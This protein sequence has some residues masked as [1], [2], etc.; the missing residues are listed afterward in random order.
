MFYV[1][2]K[3]VLM[4]LVYVLTLNQQRHQSCDELDVHENRNEIFISINFHEFDYEHPIISLSKDINP[5][6]QLKMRRICV[7]PGS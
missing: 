3:L 6:F 4:S 2:R 7:A 1:S 5:Y